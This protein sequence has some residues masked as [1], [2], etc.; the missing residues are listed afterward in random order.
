MLSKIVW[1]GFAENKPS[2]IT[3]QTVAQTTAQTIP[4]VGGDAFTFFLWIPSLEIHIS[5]EN[6]W[7]FS[8]LVVK[9]R[10]EKSELILAPIMEI[11]LQPR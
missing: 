9:G 5:K 1:Q 3:G 2:K 4:Y 8:L 10:G 6:C 7:L 11:L